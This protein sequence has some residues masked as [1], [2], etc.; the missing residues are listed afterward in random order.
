M[1]KISVMGISA[2]VYSTTLQQIDGC[3]KPI[4][5]KAQREAVQGHRI[6]TAKLK[7]SDFT[8]NHDF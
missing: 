6:V 4:T 8:P 3:P 5:D 7:S 2:V 1:N